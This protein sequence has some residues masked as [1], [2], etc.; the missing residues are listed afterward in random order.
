MH[1]HVAVDDLQR[2]I[3]FYSALFAAQP[4]VLKPDYA[5]WMLDDPRVTLPSRHTR[6]RPGSERSTAMSAPSVVAVAGL[7]TAAT[8]AIVGM[9]FSWSFTTRSS[10]I[11]FAD[12]QD[13]ALSPQR[14]KDVRLN[15][16]AALPSGEASQSCSSSSV[17]GYR[18]LTPSK[19]SA[20][21]SSLP[22]AN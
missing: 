3:G 21:L 15:S 4:S 14:D 10:L 19:S 5:K 12:Y 16:V 7:S 1:V 8:A 2:S 18:P 9:C 6:A 11:P 17:L 13:R 22:F 20:G